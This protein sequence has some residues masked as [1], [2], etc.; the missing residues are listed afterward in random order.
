M[1]DE[2]AKLLIQALLGEDTKEAPKASTPA[3]N[4]RQFRKLRVPDFNKVTFKVEDGLKVSKKVLGK[5][6]AV[7]KEGYDKRDYAKGT[8]KD[9][10]KELT[11]ATQ[12]QN[13]KSVYALAMRNRAIGPARVVWCYLDNPRKWIAKA[14]YSFGEDNKTIIE[15]ISPNGQFGW[16]FEDKNR[17]PE[18]WK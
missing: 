12:H 8:I 2:L 16:S 17:I 10:G 7:M 3:T 1:R 18:N 6:V 13:G 9:N 11:I 5:I 15:V 4:S 14:R